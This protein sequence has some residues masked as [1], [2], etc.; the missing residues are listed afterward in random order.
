MQMRRVRSLV[1][2]MTAFLIVLLVLVEIGNSKHTNTKIPVAYSYVNLEMGGGEVNGLVPTP[3]PKP[4]LDSTPDPGKKNGKKE[5][6]IREE[7]VVKE[8]YFPYE[9]LSGGIKKALHE[10]FLEMES[11]TRGNIGATLNEF[12]ANL[13]AYE[14]QLKVIRFS[15]WKVAISIA[16]I[17]APLILCIVVSTSLKD[18]A[19]SITGY[20]VARESLLNWV[21]SI[22]A[23]ASSFYFLEKMIELSKALESAIA[24]Q[25]LKSNKETLH[26]I[27]AT[28]LAE[29]LMPSPSGF[30]QHSVLLLIV[31]IIFSLLLF[32]AYTAALTI[33]W[34]ALKVIIIFVVAI[35]PIILIS[36]VLLPFRWLQGL[37]FKV[38]TIALLLWPLNMFML[39]IFSKVIAVF[40][41][42]ENASVSN[43]LFAYF[44][45]VGII[46]IFIAVNSMI[47]KLVYGS[48]I[49]IALK[50]KDMIFNLA[51]LATGSSSGVMLA[52]ASGVST[53]NPSSG[54]AGSNYNSEFTNEPSPQTSSIPTLTRSDKVG[55]G[56]P[57]ID[58]GSAN[59]Q[60]SQN[61]LANK[62]KNEISG[63]TVEDLAT[64]ADNVTKVSSVLR[65][66]YE[67]DDYLQD[68]IQ[69][70]VVPIRAS[71]GILQSDVAKATKSSEKIIRV[72][73][74]KE[75]AENAMF[76]VAS[77]HD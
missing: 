56:N 2:T 23:A 66:D 3:S 22:A 54:I 64:T 72:L 42:S 21:I 14:Q 62:L 65:P 70:L 68:R 69:K 40:I 46:S 32:M 26:G 36:G 77:K 18:G 38:T 58:K 12:E 37:W 48:A 67:S 16:G 17:L 15:A 34:F 76:D 35:A 51:S 74:K 20:A 45:A 43:T 25:F 73:K 52:G 60:D 24:S 41:S 31:L 50:S 28:Q 44:I 61:E 13:P 29:T 33:A 6:I 9:G 39:G 53:R 4:E 75:N 63:N 49:E 1:I 19:I 47:G 8:I 7:T 71:K 11:G 27:G 57:V 55:V 10:M 5:V 30:T 59:Y